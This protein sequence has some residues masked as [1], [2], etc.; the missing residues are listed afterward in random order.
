[1]GSHRDVQLARRR[2]LDDHYQ[3]HERVTAER[4]LELVHHWWLRPDPVGNHRGDAVA[5]TLVRVKSLI[6]TTLV[7][8]E[9]LCVVDSVDGT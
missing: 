5:L 2:R 8:V 6:L 7:R 1:M 4:T 3:L 9:A